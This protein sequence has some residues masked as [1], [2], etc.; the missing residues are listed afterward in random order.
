MAFLLQKQVRSDLELVMWFMR[1]KVD[2]L[3]SFDYYVDCES[4][5]GGAKSGITLLHVLFISSVVG[6]RS[7]Q[8]PNTYYSN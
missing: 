6:T 3:E 4:E 2:E 1:I 7:T 8:K 5:H